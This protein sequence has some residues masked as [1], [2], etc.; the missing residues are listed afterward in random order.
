MINDTG[1]CEPIRV[2]SFYRSPYIRGLLIIATIRRVKWPV[3]YPCSVSRNTNKNHKNQ[4]TPSVGLLSPRMW[5]H[6]SATWRHAVYSMWFV[7][8]HL[9]SEFLVHLRWLHKVGRGCPSVNICVFWIS[10]I[11]RQTVLKLYMMLLDI[12]PHDRCRIFD[13]RSC[14]LE[15]RIP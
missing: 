7:V 13:F 3:I 11:Y 6:V 4:E 9:S 8:D 15:M 14:D 1:Y 2:P 5:R 12:G 10:H